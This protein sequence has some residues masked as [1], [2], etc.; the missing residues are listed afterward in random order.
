MTT[1]TQIPEKIQP[2]DLRVN[3]VTKVI[4][5]APAGI[6]RMHQLH[7]VLTDLTADLESGDY[8]RVR[9]ALIEINDEIVRF[10]RRVDEMIAEQREQEYQQRRQ[11]QIDANKARARQHCGTLTGSR[12]PAWLDA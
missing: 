1:V 2:I 6:S 3:D 8:R 5:L 4:A 12:R 7:F 11:A 10:N 9:T